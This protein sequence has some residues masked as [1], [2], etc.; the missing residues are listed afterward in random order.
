MMRYPPL[1]ETACDYE[2]IRE[3]IDDI[4]SRRHAGLESMM[5]Q[6]TY[7]GI[8]DATFVLVQFGTKLLMLDHADFSKELFYQLA[9]RRFGCADRLK[10]STPVNLAEFVRA[11]LDSEEA[12]WTE[13]DGPKE[14]VAENITNLL[15]EKGA[16]LNE[17]FC[18]DISEGG[19]LLS[20]PELLQGHRPLPEVLPLFLIRLATEVNW[21]DEKLCFESIATIL[22][23][24]YAQLP[25]ETDRAQQSTMDR[26]WRAKRL[27]GDRG[28][29]I[30]QH[31]ILPAM[32][33]Y[34]I[35]PKEFADD[36]S[37]VQVA[38]LE[39]LYRVFERC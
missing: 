2:S 38:A 27:L 3:L 28:S 8:V 5:K 12:Q 13:E 14:V 18:I 1:Q 29:Q 31:Q 25:V 35:P 24:Y 11:G 23:W 21:E 6:H 4:R 33:A 37:V 10:L 30:L 20:L 9:I 7:V 39:Q 22:A 26:Q 16:M 32:K 15:I 19:E 17:Y 36:G 34:F